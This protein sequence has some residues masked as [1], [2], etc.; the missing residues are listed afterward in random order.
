MGGTG[1]HAH[2]FGHE[3]IAVELIIR[4]DP[5]IPGRDGIGP[6]GYIFNKYFGDGPGMT[7]DPPGKKPPP[8][9]N[10]GVAPYHPSF[11]NIYLPAHFVLFL[12]HVPSCPHPER[13]GWGIAAVSGGQTGHCWSGPLC[14]G[15]VGSR[16]FHAQAV[17]P[18]W[19]GVGCVCERV[20]VKRGGG[21]SGIL[22]HIHKAT[23][24][25]RLTRPYIDRGTPRWSQKRWCRIE[26]SL[27]D[28]ALS[29]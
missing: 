12:T 28:R 15:S 3:G 6:G 10:C 29:W 16:L 24:T 4:V 8:D 26:W 17:F 18:T 19:M 13:V 21:G 14:P 9:R 11:P 27:C 1:Q 2:R 22:V 7:A 23:A 5:V 25:L 20:G